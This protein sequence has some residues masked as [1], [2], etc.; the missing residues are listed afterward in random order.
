MP[1]EFGEGGPRWEHPPGRRRGP[2]QSRRGGSERNERR[3][4]MSP[5]WEP[6][7]S[8]VGTIVPISAKPKPPP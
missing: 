7:A 2:D 5:P 4:M 8:V 1:P 6:F 3:D